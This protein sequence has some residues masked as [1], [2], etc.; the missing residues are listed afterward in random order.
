M[1]AGHVHIVKD[2]NRRFP[3]DV[4][5]WANAREQVA[6][7]RGGD[8]DAWFEHTDHRRPDLAI[9]VLMQLGLVLDAGAKVM[10]GP[11]GDTGRPAWPTQGDGN[12]GCR[13]PSSSPL[14]R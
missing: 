6:G 13:P 14:R 1:P 9:P 11:D 7:P 10:S 4:H 3:G 5:L 12:V 8:S 2:G